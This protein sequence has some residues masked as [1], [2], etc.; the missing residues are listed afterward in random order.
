MN[1]KIYEFSLK[2]FLIILKTERL[3]KE[4]VYLFLIIQLLLKL[5]FDKQYLKRIQFLI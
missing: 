4:R 2:F 5:F 3:K 1:V